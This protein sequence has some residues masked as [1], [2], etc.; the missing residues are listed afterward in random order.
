MKLFE[1]PPPFFLN[2]YK[3]K[4][5]L[6]RFS[7]TMLVCTLVRASPVVP[8]LIGTPAKVQMSPPPFSFTWS[9]TSPPRTPTATNRP[10]R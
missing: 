1:A 6:I 10:D 4:M 2:I 7:Q 3:Y 9:D 8:S 5:D